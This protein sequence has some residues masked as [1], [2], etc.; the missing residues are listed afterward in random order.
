MNYTHNCNNS[1]ALTFLKKLTGLQLVKKYSALYGNRWFVTAYR[2]VE[3]ESE[4]IVGGV[5][6]NF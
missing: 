6:R 1:G 5:G 2:A 3:S 4:G